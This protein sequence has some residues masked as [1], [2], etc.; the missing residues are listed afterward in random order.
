MYR[1]T[2]R[3]VVS[4]ARSGGDRANWRPGIWV[5]ILVLVTDEVFLRRQTSRSQSRS[6]ARS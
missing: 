4:Q 2:F 5:R 1:D 3:A 6:G